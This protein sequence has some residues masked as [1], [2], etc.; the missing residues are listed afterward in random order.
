VDRGCQSG[1]AATD[2][3][4]V[5]GQ[6]RGVVYIDEGWQ[7]IVDSLH[8]SAVAAGVNFVTSSRVVRVD[9]DGVV[10]G[11]ELGGL[12][13]EQQTETASYVLPQPGETRGTRLAAETVLLAV[14]PSTARD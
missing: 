11:I 3:D 2:D 5:L 8:S 10:Q 12:E 9:H 4:D 7:K 14:E 6:M 13:F 1:D